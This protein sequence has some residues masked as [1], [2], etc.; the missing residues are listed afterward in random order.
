M[1]KRLR[2]LLLKGIGYLVVA[3]VA[4]FVVATVVSLVAGIVATIVSTL[5]VLTILVLAAV[6]LGSLL[7][8]GSDSTRQA[9][10]SGGNRDAAGAHRDGW[11]ERFPGG[12]STTST[13]GPDHVDRLQEQYVTGEISEVEFERRLALLLE[14]DDTEERLGGSSATTTRNW[15]RSRNG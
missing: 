14:S 5:V 7:L 4:L 2:A 8:T 9:G 11:R 12:S 15:D 10:S 13:A 3:L 6:G 1:G